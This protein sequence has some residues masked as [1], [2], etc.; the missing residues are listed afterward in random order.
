MNEIRLENMC[1]MLHTIDDDSGPPRTG[2][3]FDS[4][5]PKL[6]I[7][8]VE[9]ENM[10][11][12]SWKLS[13]KLATSTHRQRCQTASRDAMTIFSLF[14]FSRLYSPRQQK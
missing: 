3:S 10:T 1:K 14:C 5:D 11:T 6:L 9:E 8:A 12:T 7:P 13:S 4:L 2:K